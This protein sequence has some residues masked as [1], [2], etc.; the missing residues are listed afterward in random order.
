M[1]Y[2]SQS[3][4]VPENKIKKCKMSKINYQIASNFESLWI[5]NMPI[6]GFIIKL[7][8]KTISYLP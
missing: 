6:K 8:F 7:E 3:L 4:N 2:Q 1:E 5:N